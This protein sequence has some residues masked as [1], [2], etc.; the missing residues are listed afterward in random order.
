MSETQTEAVEPRQVVVDDV[1]HVVDDLPANVQSLIRAYDAWNVDRAEAQRKATQLDAAVRFL[2]QQIQD[3]I[4]QHVAAQDAA[5]ATP[6]ADEE[7][8]ETAT[9]S[10][11]IPA[12]DGEAD[13]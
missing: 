6:V 12:E 3:A 10:L 2:A 9:A 5:Q 7:G 4:R 8:A 1:S 13:A 11:D